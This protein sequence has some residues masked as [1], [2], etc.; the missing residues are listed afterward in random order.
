MHARLAAQQFTATGGED[1]GQRRAKR[2]Q[3]QSAIEDVD[4]LAEP[5]LC[6]EEAVEDHPG[7]EDLCVI[8]AGG[9]PQP[10][11]AHVGQFTADDPTLIRRF[12]TLLGG[13]EIEVVDAVTFRRGLVVGS[14]L[15]QFFGGKAAE[16]GVHGI[17]PLF[18]PQQRLFNEQEQMLGIG[19][20]NHSS[21]LCRKSAVK[22]SQAR[23]DVLTF[24]RQQAPGVLKSGTQAAMT[25][26]CITH[27]GCKEVQPA[28]D[29]VG[30][31]RGGEVPDPHRRQF[32][33]Q[34]HSF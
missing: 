17:A 21:R 28:T 26:G 18:Q 24:L 9:G 20:G 33:P 12:S 30:N 34:W 23:K 10:G 16:H 2:P 4:P 8:L 6:A 29:F 14:V 5:A 19:P 25:F 27:I 1:G 32:D 15:C 11:G 13:E 7:P 31:L 22:G 3:I